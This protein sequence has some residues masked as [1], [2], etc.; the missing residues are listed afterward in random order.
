MHQMSEHGIEMLRSVWSQLATKKIIRSSPKVL[1][2]KNCKPKTCSLICKCVREEKIILWIIGN[3]NSV[4]MA[5]VCDKA[6]S[7]AV[8]EINCLRPTKLWK[9]VFLLI[10]I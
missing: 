9:N 10:D 2:T 1:L 8:I 6:K 4:S 3:E 5:N 7:D